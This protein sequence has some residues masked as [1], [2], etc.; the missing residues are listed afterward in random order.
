MH[1]R[2]K[3]VPR[4]ASV[5]YSKSDGAYKYTCSSYHIGEKESPYIYSSSS[6]AI[7]KGKSRL[8]YEV[9]KKFTEGWSK[10]RVHAVIKGDHKSICGALVEK[11]KIKG[12]IVNKPCE[13]C[14]KTITKLI[15]EFG[16]DVGEEG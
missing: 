14:A 2:P 3:W 13:L 10:T 15:S 11:K 16:G 4:G 8:R 7:S 6:I 12:T 5:L 1:D 9:F